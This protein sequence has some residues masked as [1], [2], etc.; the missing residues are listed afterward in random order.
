[1]TNEQIIERYQIYLI[2][3][4][5]LN[6]ASIRNYIYTLKAFISDLNNKSLLEVTTDDVNEYIRERKMKGDKNSRITF[7]TSVLSTFYKYLHK[8]AKLIKNNP[9]KDVKRVKY[10]AKKNEDKDVISVYHLYEIRRKLKEHG[11]KELEC[12]FSLL[13][14]SMP[15]KQSIINAKW[16]KIDYDNNY[17]EVEL[18]EENK[19]ILYIDNYTKEL[20]I[21]LRKERRRVDIRNP[22]IF[23]CRHKNRWK[24]ISPATINVWLNK[25]AKIC[26]LDTLTMGILKRSTMLYWS[27]ARK[28]SDE[29]I[30]L[31]KTHRKYNVEFEEIIQ[32]EKNNLINGTNK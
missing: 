14:S 23:I 20:L 12:F 26:E 3:Y 19:G 32:N 4:R 30:S 24:P 6:E 22:H 28:M 9:M 27:N 15:T 10:K 17:I 16:R 1:M 21:E 8:N 7:V 18:D 5:D 29:K 25:I 13:M 31:I 2:R 11:D